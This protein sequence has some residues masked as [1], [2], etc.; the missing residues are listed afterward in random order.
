MLEIAG[1]WIGAMEIG[2][3]SFYTDLIFFTFNI[4][5]LVNW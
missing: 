3:N 5:Y 2:D 4:Y 1:D